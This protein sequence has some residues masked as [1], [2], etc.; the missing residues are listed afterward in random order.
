MVEVEHLKLDNQ[1]LLALLKSTKEFKEFADIA[2]ASGGR[3]HFAGKPTPEEA[4]QLAEPKNW[5]PT[6]ALRLANQFRIRNESVSEPAMNRLLAELNKV[7]R[8]RET[9]RVAK[10]QRDC[11]TEVSDL[12][13]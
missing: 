6:E 13:R 7:W 8:D 4:K 1:R 9:K 3:I 12:R 11:N 2:D 5:M 10:I